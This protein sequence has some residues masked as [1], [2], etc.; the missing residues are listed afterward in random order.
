MGSRP[1]WATQPDTARLQ[2]MGGAKG[3]QSPQATPPVA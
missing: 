3:S 1:A 2:K